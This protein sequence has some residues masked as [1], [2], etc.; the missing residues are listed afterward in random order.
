MKTKNIL[1][2]SVFLILFFL[3][4]GIIY[5]IVF[6]KDI[7]FYF[8]SFLASSLLFCFSFG[9]IIFAKGCNNNLEYEKALINRYVG[10]VLILL[11][12]GCFLLIIME[13]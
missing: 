12:F 5:L 9:F 3:Q 13:L 4:S 7:F 2:Y 6:Q 1:L 8:Q 10:L 11:S